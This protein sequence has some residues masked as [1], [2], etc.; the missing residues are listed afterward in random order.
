MRPRRLPAAGAARPRRALLRLRERK[1]RAVVLLDRR[2]A[3][4]ADLPRGLER[5]PA[6]GARLAEPRRAHGADEELLLDLGA[7]DGA[8]QVAR[9]EPLLH[10]LD[11]EFA[12]AHVLEVLRRTE[13]HVDQR[14]NERHDSDRG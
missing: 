11:L 9:A 10:C 6:G 4:R 1:G 8:A 7:T 2:L 5:P 13:E 14:P 12:L 3:V